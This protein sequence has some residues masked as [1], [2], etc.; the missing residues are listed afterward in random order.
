MFVGD[1]VAQ[2][3]RHPEKEIDV[4]RNLVMTSWNTFFFAPVFFYWFGFL[5]RKW[6]SKGPRAALTKVFVNAAVVTLPTNLLFLGY[7]AVFENVLTSRRLD[8]RAIVDDF[9][10]RVETALPALCKNSVLLWVPFN[11][12]NFLLVPAQF[13]V[14]PTIVGSLAWNIY[15]SFASHDIEAEDAPPAGI[16]L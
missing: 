13:R 15:A 9:E 7:S 10:E 8:Q 5:D 16:E 2:T 14:L 1:R 6:P 11:A 12:L 4:E 3:I